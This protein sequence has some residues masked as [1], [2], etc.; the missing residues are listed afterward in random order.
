MHTIVHCILCAVLPLHVCLLMP[1]ARDKTSSN[2]CYLILWLFIHTKPSQ[3]PLLFVYDHLERPSCV[4]TQKK[5]HPRMH[6]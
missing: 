6:A 1:H 5:V 3:C 4:S 2:A